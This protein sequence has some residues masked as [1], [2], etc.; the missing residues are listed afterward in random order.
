[1][2]LHIHEQPFYAREQRLVILGTEVTVAPLRP[3][4]WISLT[5]PQ[6]LS[7]SPDLPRFLALVDTGFNGA[8]FLSADHLQRL[9]DVTTLLEQSPGNVRLADSRLESYRRYRARIWLHSYGLDQPRP[10]LDL[11]ISRGVLVWAKPSWEAPQVLEEGFFRKLL[12]KVWP[13]HGSQSAPGPSPV[14]VSQGPALPTLG[15]WALRPKKL[16][17]TADYDLLGLSIGVP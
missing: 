14:P 8:L 1:V 13:W 16:K 15:A 3:L 6:V 2:P 17:V 7:L 11:D 9:V 10:A 12:R 5:A 4:V